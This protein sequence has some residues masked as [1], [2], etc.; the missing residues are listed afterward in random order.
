VVGPPPE[1]QTTNSRL[2]PRQPCA[3]SPPVPQADPRPPHPDVLAACSFARSSALFPTAEPSRP[4]LSLSFLADEV[5]LGR[6]A[7]DRARTRV[8]R[9]LTARPA[10]A[11]LPSRARKHFPSRMPI[12]RASP[13]LYQ[14]DAT[15][16]APLANS[17]R[18]RKIAAHETTSGRSGTELPSDRGIFAYRTHRS[19]VHDAQW[20]KRGI[21][22]WTVSRFVF[23]AGDAS[24]PSPLRIVRE[25]DHRERGRD[26]RIPAA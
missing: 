1:S 14:R 21:S 22:R 8:A 17:N 12:Y 3:S 10:R 2:T 24:S 11:G 26:E 18:F 20:I 16:A 5:A 13:N 9:S 23:N 4:S 6:L 25:P 19:T 7:L 15:A